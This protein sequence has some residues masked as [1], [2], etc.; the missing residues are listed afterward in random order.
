MLLKLLKLL[1][2]VQ[3]S[4]Q[5]EVGDPASVVLP[6][7]FADEV[8]DDTGENSSFNRVIVEDGGLVIIIL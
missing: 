3:L 2:A 6:R 8:L 1:L 7:R 5:K 4:G